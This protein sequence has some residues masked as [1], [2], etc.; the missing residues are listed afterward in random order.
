LT[1]QVIVGNRLFKTKRVKQ[2]T[3]VVIVPPHHRPTPPRIVSERRN[4]CSRGPSTTFAT[5]SAISRHGRAQLP[6]LPQ[7]ACA[8][9]PPMFYLMANPFHVRRLVIAIQ[10]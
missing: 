9:A 3:L 10:T 2:P 5:K 7:N 4:H 8:P 1:N 6:S